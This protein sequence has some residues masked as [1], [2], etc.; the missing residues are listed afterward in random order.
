VPSVDLSF[1]G[2]DGRLRARIKDQNLN[3]AQS[4]AEYRQTCAMFSDAASSIYR[5][6]RSLRSGSALRDIARYVQSG[7]R[8]VPGDI[9][10]QWL[11]IQYGARPLMS[12]IYGAADE[13][14]KSLSDGYYRH[15]RTSSTERYEGATR[16]NCQLDNVV[17]F[18]Y[19]RHTQKTVKKTV[20]ARYRITAA[21]L[22]Q[23][24]Q[25][26]VTNP[27]LL[28]WELI[29]YSFVFDWMIPVGTYLA[30]LDALAGVGDLSVQRSYRI[31]RRTTASAGDIWEEEE[32][33]QRLAVATSLSLP[34]LAYQ[35]SRSLMAVANGVALLTQLRSALR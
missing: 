18:P 28:I 8:D 12:D 32:S 21:G 2:L 33:F 13:L 7:N 5:A 35:P 15:L 11:R 31:S 20:R 30:S 25:I 1:N 24:S 22:K 16:L 3:M 9:A 27:A 6:F 26:G 14:T 10:N 34:R 4:V 23:L 29:P 17:L 19:T